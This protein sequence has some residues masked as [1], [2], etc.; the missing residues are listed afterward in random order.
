[1]EIPL[2]P[3]LHLWMLIQP[4]AGE[5]LL[6]GEENIRVGGRGLCVSREGWGA[7]T[8]GRNVSIF[9]PKHSWIEP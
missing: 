2:G 9:A 4:S 5:I 7:A 1:M 8:G 3:S 6:R